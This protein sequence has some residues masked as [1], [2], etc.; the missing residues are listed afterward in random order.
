MKINLQSENK[1]LKYQHQVIHGKVHFV[2][3]QCELTDV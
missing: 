2:K 1:I 3:L